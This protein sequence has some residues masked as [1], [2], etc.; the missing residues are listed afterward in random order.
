MF[1]SKTFSNP[2]SKYFFH[3]IPRGGRGR[4]R[5]P[6]EFCCCFRF[7]HLYTKIT[8]KDVTDLRS[9][10]CTDAPSPQMKEGGVCTRVTL[11]AKDTESIALSGL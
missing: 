11:P 9:L 5:G 7:L 4:L 3:Q 6:K 2:N 8:C 10:L 1:C